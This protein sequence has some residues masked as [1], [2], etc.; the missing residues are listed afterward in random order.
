MRGDG[1]HRDDFVVPTGDSRSLRNPAP[2]TPELGRPRLAALIR[3]LPTVLGRHRLVTPG[4]VLRWHRRL[5]TKKWTY[6]N[7]PGRPSIDSIVARLVEHMAA[8]N[9]SGA[10]AGSKAGCSSSGTVS[11]RNH[12][13]DP[14]MSPLPAGS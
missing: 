11:A 14:A 8:E 5:V 2:T 9:P 10:T 3:R 1:R 4:T 12:P 7:R 13:P 6:P